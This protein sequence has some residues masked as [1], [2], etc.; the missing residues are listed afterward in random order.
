M[1]WFDLLGVFVWFASFRCVLWQ[2]CAASEGL[3]LFAQRGG[4]VESSQNLEDGDL[5][6]ILFGDD[7]GCERLRCFSFCFMFLSKFFF[8][9]GL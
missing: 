3:A 7:V 9:T 6:R 8:F 4:R 1:V 5:T 2:T